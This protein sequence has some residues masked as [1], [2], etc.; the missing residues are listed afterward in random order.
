MTMFLILFFARGAIVFAFALAAVRL[1]QRASASLRFAVLVSALAAVL[2]LP[3]L[4]ALVPTWHTGALA[5]DAAGAIVS[6]PALPVAETGPA[7]S[8]HAAAPIVHAAHR[9]IP[10]GT[11]LAA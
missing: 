2:V 3:V 10:W 1:L 5:P 7:A 4:G 9:A 6:S 11:L 8:A